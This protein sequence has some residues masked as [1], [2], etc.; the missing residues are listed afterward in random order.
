MAWQGKCRLDG[1]TDAISRS[2]GLRNP[3]EDRVSLLV[4]PPGFVVSAREPRSNRGRQDVNQ[5]SS[6]RG[7]ARTWRDVSRPAPR[8]HEPATCRSSSGSWTTGCS[9]LSCPRAA[10][11][12]SSATCIIRSVRSTSRRA[13]RGW[14]TSSST[15]S[16]R[17]PSGSPRGRSTGSRSSP[18]GSP[19][20]RRARTARTTGSP[21]LRPLGARPPGRGRPDAR[22]RFDPGEVEAERQVIGEERARE[23]DSPLARLDQTHLA[24]S[25]LRHPYRN[26]ILGWPDDLARIGVDDLQAFYRDHYRPD[27]AVLVLVGDVD[28]ARALDR[29]EAQFGAIR[30]GQTAPAASGPGT[31]RARRAGATS[32]WSSPKS[33]RAGCSAGTPCR[34][35][36]ATARRSTSWPTCSARAA[37]AALADPGRAGQA[38]DL[39][40]GRARPGAAGRA[41]LRPGRGRSPGPTRPCWSER[42]VEILARA[43][44]ARADRGRSWPG[45]ETGSRPPGGG[46]RKTSPAWPRASAM[47]PSGTTGATGRPSMPPRWPSTP[48]PSA[49]SPLD[50]WPRA[51]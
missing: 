50:T 10:C 17:G 37:V 44:R 2:R 51:T 11:R 15:C 12:S 48:P 23:L 1:R 32:R 27:G 46:S 8:A 43:G 30:R 31:S 45:R 42:I 3:R 40:R 26:P 16:S 38:G 21:S 35:G 9:A 14:P 47:P 20:P 19:T 24:V 7:A 6:N 33:C 5:S 4:R 39:G 13:R 34:A 49:G 36:I 25:Y 28:P 41:V 29:I 22:A 18:P